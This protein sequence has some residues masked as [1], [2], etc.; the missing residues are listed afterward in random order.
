LRLAVSGTDVASINFGLGEHYFTRAH[1]AQMHSILA[2]AAAHHLTV[3]AG[4]GDNGGFSDD[5]F[6]GTPVKEVSGMSGCTSTAG[7]APRPAGAASRPA[8]SSWTP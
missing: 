3:V 7:S 4:S 5:W 2:G 8:G 1:V 6:E